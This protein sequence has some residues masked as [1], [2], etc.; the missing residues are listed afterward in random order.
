MP[1]PAFNQVQFGNLKINS[2]LQ[3]IDYVGRI[4]YNQ[5]CESETINLST[6]FLNPGFYIIRCGNCNPKQLVKL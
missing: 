4:C 2:Y 5:K 6:E 1:N 3:I